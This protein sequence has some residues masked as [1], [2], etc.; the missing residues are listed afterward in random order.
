MN[1]SQFYDHLIEKYFNSEEPSAHSQVGQLSYYKDLSLKDAI[2]DAVFGRYLIE[3]HQYF[4]YHYKNFPQ[5]ERAQEKAREN[6]LANI[7]Q[8][9]K[10]KDFLQLYH[11]VRRITQDI[12]DKLG[13]LF[14][15]DTALRL[16][17]CKD[18]NLSP[19]H[20]FLQRGSLLGAEASGVDLTGNTFDNPYVNRNRFVPL[21]SKFETA[22]SK[23][24]EA[25]LCVY[26]KEI[27]KFMKKV[28]S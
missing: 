6:L 14:Y 8:I 5:A 26:H 2:E 23:D 4:S 22:E 25:L 9:K 15:Y 1:I 27:E 17:A 21:S 24:I 19:L 12:S 28:T 3:G 13:R 18:L 10:S 7:A 20:V 11:Q 16:G